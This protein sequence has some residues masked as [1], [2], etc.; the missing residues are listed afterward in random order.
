MLPLFKTLLEGDLYYAKADHKVI[1]AKVEKDGNVAYK[2]IFT[3]QLMPSIGHYDAKKILVNNSLRVYL[4]NAIARIQ[5][6]AKSPKVR[7]AAVR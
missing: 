1:L 4:R 6:T 3:N 7:E 5:L 2:G